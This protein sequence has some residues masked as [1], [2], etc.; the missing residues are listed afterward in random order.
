M[1][2]GNG[3]MGT[4]ILRGGVSAAPHLSLLVH[5]RLHFQLLLAPIF[6]WGFWLA[7]GRPAPSALVAFALFHIFL[8]GGATAFNSAYDRDKG[9]VGG[10]EHPPAVSRSLLPF[11][12][13]VL[14]IGWALSAAVN[15]PFFCV[16]GAILGFALAYSH[17]IVR[18]KAGPLTS[19][20]TIFL[21]QGVLGF[22]GGWV[23]A[24]MPLAGVLTHGG[25]IGMLATSLL[26]S[27]FYPLG[28]LY[29]VEEDQARGDRTV[30]VAWGPQRCFRLSQAAFLLGSGAVVSLILPRHGAAEAGLAS[31]FL[32]AILAATE[33]WRRTF[34]PL[35]IMANFHHA[36]R[37]NA[38]AAVALGGYVVWHMAAG[39]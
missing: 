27:G 24:G 19:L 23:A 20:L 5:L 34:R 10:L 4:I 33:A 13:A 29:Q 37:L 6:L 38:A 32:L 26:V 31:L 21:G 14:L 11:S 2:R 36:M 8:Y 18:W 7:G 25:L 3:R 39:N 12:V 9:P 30:A 15:W 16:Y 35:E 1:M 28:Q 22:L 17:P